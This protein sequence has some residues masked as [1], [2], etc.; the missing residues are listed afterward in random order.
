[1]MTPEEYAA[2]R[3]GID[4]GRRERSKFIVDTLRSFGIKMSVGGCGCCGSPDVSFTYNGQTV[5]GEGFNFDT[6]DTE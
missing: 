2:W 3:K 6:E 4:D 5:K 1:M